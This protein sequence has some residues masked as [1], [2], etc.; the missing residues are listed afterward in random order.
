MTPDE[1][2]QAKA[3][4]AAFRP[5]EAPKQPRLRR[6]DVLRAMGLVH[7]PTEYERAFGYY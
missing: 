5:K 1:I 7:E 3:G 4:V 6:Q 2:E